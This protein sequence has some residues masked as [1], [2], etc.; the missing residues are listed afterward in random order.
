MFGILPIG[1]SM[2]FKGQ[3]LFQKALEQPN[4]YGFLLE[5]P[6]LDETFFIEKPKLSNVDVI[7]SNE[8]QVSIQPQ[9][10]E[11]IEMIEK[12]K[13]E[14]KLD[15]EPQTQQVVKVEKK[16][17]DIIFQSVKT[18]VKSENEKKPLT[19]EQTDNIK[20]ILDE[21]NKLNA[22]NNIIQGIQNNL[23]SNPSVISSIRQV[24]NV[25]QK[26]SLKIKE[27]NKS[28][29][30]NQENLQKINELTRQITDTKNQNE[31]FNKLIKKQEKQ[32]KTKNTKLEK[33]KT[34]IFNLQ[35]TLLKQGQEHKNELQI[36]KQKHKQNI[37]NLKNQ[38]QNFLN[39]KKIQVETEKK[40]IREKG[41][42]FRQ[43]GMKVEKQRDEARQL[44]LQTRDK[45]IQFKSER[46]NLNKNLQNLSNKGR[47][48]F[49]KLIQLKGENTEMKNFIAGQKGRINQ[50]QFE[51]VLLSKALDT[52]NTQRKN[53]AENLKQSLSNKNIQGVANHTNE[54][55]DKTGQTSALLGR[56]IDKILQQAK[57]NTEQKFIQNI[58]QQNQNIF[59]RTAQLHFRYNKIKN[60]MISEKVSTQQGQKGLL[61]IAGEM[62]KLFTLQ[63]K[64]I[65]DARNFDKKFKVFGNSPQNKNSPQPNKQNLKVSRRRGRPNNFKKTKSI[66]APKRPPPV[67]QHLRVA[68][69]GTFENGDV[70]MRDIKQRTLEKF[71]N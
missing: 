13:D 12:V 61:S 24:V 50:I 22:P 52:F 39:K 40:Q 65:N 8:E 26:N 9:D 41:E 54:L 55:I 64:L 14:E 60:D 38:A 29:S 43:Q 51:N 21:L 53:L 6:M 57:G 34:T 35:E 48:Q 44:A 67:P 68:K 66:T 70:N 17:E 71:R 7:V 16:N 15:I 36:L 59:Q 3:K 58:Q 63:Q 1:E 56:N 4:L 28:N 49:K 32:I 42:Q 18:N 23:L 5:I 20:L 19:Q 11:D 47:K 27:L 33:T 46:D 31:T 2:I 30:T 10:K 25:L 45:A 69:R 37:Q 62:K